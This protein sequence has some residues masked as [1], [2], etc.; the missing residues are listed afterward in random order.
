MT[1]ERSSTNGGSS[2]SSGHAAPPA[3]DWDTLGFGLAHVGHTMF[4]ASCTMVDGKAVWEEGH[5]V[6]YGPIPM[7]PSAQ[8][9]NYGQGVFEGMKAQRSA[10]GRIVLF[11]PDCNA[12]RMAAGAVR[13]SMAPPPTDLFLRAVVDTVLANQARA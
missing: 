2:S 10:A 7:Y 9:L 12:E 3:I 5:L 4:E 11:R 8:V 13:M 1:A 6:P